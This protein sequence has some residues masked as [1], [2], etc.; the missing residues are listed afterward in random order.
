[1]KRG[2]LEFRRSAIGLRFGD[3]LIRA[4]LPVVP[5]TYGHIPEAQ[6]PT[7]GGWGMLGNLTAG[8]C[9]VAKA[10]HATQDWF[11]ATGKPV[12][13][14]TDASA[15]ALYSAMLVAQ[16]GLPYDPN[17]PATDAGLD[18]VA[19][20][21]FWQTTGITD[22]DGAVHKIGP[23]TAIDDADE[24]DLAGYLGGAAAVCW[25]LPST[26]E[27]QFEAGEV[28]DDVSQPPGDGHDT[29]LGGRNSAGNRMVVTWGRL[30]AFTESYRAKY[31]VGGLSFASQDYLL[32]TG[33]TPEAI[34]WAQL[35]A[36]QQSIAQGE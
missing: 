23:F 3:I 35:A 1:M 29:M 34:D 26:A 10:C 36:Y 14:F 8:D 31:M 22:A 25:A 24:L 11:W 2:M 17:D 13:R 12:P 33:K 15:L 16:G 9:V 27:A 32:A 5:K 18:P 30:Q 6:P 28:W 4:K 7:A 19:A 21:Q 20:A